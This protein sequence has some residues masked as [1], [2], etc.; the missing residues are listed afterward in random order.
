MSDRRFP[1]E[2]VPQDVYDSPEHTRGN[3][4]AQ[5]VGSWY[6]GVFT[7]D[8]TSFGED[9]DRSPSDGEVASWSPKEV[10]SDITVQ[11]LIASTPGSA[12]LADRGSVVMSQRVRRRW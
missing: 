8:T 10:E 6:A 4:R 2:W 12:D 11:V 9:D 7:D 5:I 3:P 1:L